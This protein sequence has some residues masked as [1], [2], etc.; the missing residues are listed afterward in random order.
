MSGL[1]EFLRLGVCLS[2][3]QVVKAL[4]SGLWNSES[5]LVRLRRPSA[6]EYVLARSWVTE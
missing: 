5:L 1:W 4:S 3:G 2:D 6:V